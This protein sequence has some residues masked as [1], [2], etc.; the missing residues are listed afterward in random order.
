MQENVDEII[1]QLELGVRVCIKWK[2]LTG[3]LC[4]KINAILS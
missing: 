3:V 1:Q 2:Q 4:D